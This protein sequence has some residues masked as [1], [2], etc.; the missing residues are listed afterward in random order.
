M[1]PPLNTSQMLGLDLQLSHQGYFYFNF[2]GPEVNL[3][4]LSASLYDHIEEGELG[5]TSRTFFKDFTLPN[6]IGNSWRN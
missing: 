3:D 1:G 6:T 5:S 4:V 2:K